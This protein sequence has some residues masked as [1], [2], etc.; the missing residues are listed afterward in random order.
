MRKVKYLQEQLHYEG[1]VA[2]AVAQGLSLDEKK[3]PSWLLYD[4]NGDELFKKITQLEEYYPT[5]CE[6]SILKRYKE[7]IAFYF[8]QGASSFNLIE[9]GPGDG[10]KTEILL[11]YF[12]ETNLSFD[13]YP[14]DVSSAVLDQ[15]TQRLSQ[16]HQFNIH[17]IRAKYDDALSVGNGHGRNGLLFLGANIGNFT[18]AEA[19]DFVSAKTEQMNV[20]DLM[21]IGFDLKKAPRVI[22]RAYD[23][24]SG[25]TREFNLNLL[26][27]LNRE[28]GAN[29]D[30]TQ[31][32][33]YPYYDPQSGAAKSFLMS[34][35]SQS[36]YIEAL[37][38]SF[39]FQQWETINTEISQKYDLLMIDK[40]MTSAG[41]EITDIFFDEQHYFCDVL[42]TK[43]KST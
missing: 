37:S 41:L 27:R 43:R 8:S 11:R 19:S 38:K 24:A 12:A 13:Y 42:G 17:P 15:L 22:E 5:R 26:T 29:F 4:A 3:L 32:E 6:L 14:V 40:L 35:R 39:Y 30:L 2:E 16:Y 31:F 33:H 23:D 36:V 18:D 10:S 28:L 9:L 1:A 20:G 25:V 21:L 34:M 7:D